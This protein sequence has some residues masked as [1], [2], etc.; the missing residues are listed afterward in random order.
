[1]YSVSRKRVLR[2][3]LNKSI[4]QNQNDSYTADIFN[5]FGGYILKRLKN[6]EAHFDT[7]K[8]WLFMLL[9]YFTSSFIR[10][11]GS[12]KVLVFLHI[13]NIIHVY[14]VQK[15]ITFIPYFIL[16]FVSWY[17]V[18]NTKFITIA[19]RI[20]SNVEKCYNMYYAQKFPLP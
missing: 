20:W 1:M 3:L 11:T 16:L 19:N 6:L 13:V 14:N 5:E 12:N 15:R 8:S 17:Y 7:Y 18:C 2:M 9:I 10:P 4:I